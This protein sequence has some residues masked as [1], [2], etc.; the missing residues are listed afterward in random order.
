ML[1]HLILIFL[2][3]PIS[4][5][6]QQRVSGV[7]LDKETSKPLEFVDIY[8]KETNTSS[9]VEGRFEFSTK[10]SVVNFNLLGYEKKM[11]PVDQIKGDTIFLTNKFLELDEINISDLDHPIKA[12]FKQIVVNYPLEPYSESF[13]MRCVLKKHDEIIKIQDINGLVERQT[14]FSTSKSPMPKNN[15]NVEVKNMRKAGVK[16]KEIYFEMFSLEEFFKAIT[17]IYMSPKLYDYEMK[18]SMDSQYIKYYFSPKQNNELTSNGYYIVNSDDNA[19]DEYYLLNEE[20]NKV[21]KEKG[22]IKYR[23]YFYELSV[24]FKKDEKNTK[25]FLDIAKLTAKVEVIDEEKKSIFYN[26]EYQ[27]ITKNPSDL[28]VDNNISLSKDLF[29]LNKD[30]VPEFWQNQ[31]ELL[32]TEEMTKFING[33][34][35]NDENEYKIISN[36]KD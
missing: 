22:A 25:Y 5:L 15:Y 36:I 10:D 1:K 18:P 14:L 2:L 16:E 7:I 21:Y 3:I 8:N 23:T 9:N 30:Y 35:N 28:R 24:K 11:F 29:K 12:V 34:E 17:S 13:F 4:L 6:A 26:A 32:L 19:F 33:L 27:W 31:N 20:K